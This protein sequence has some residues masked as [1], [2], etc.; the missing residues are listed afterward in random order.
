MDQTM[1]HHP[2]VL[3]RAHRA[4]AVTLFGANHGERWGVSQYWPV[5]VRSLALMPVLYY[6]RRAFARFKRGSNQAWVRY[7]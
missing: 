4:V 6:P 5:W 1:M 7:F 3:G 2:D